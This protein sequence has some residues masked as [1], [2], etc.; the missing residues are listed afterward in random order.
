MLYEVITE[1]KHEQRFVI[2]TDF[3]TLLAIDTKTAD[4]LDIKINELPRYYDFFL[5]WAGI[6]KAQHQNE[7]PADVKAASYNFV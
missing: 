7:N 1:L 6:E 4:K 2:V 5:P 3:E